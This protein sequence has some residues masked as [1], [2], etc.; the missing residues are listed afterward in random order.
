MQVIGHKP[1][2]QQISA[3]EAGLKGCFAVCHDPIPA[4]MQQLLARVQ[5]M[6]EHGEFGEVRRV[7]RL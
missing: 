6:E 4:D 7:K 1:S 3:F 5:D 2:D